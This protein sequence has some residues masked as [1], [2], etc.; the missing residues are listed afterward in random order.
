MRIAILIC[1][2]FALVFLSLIGLSYTS[3]T[4]F[5]VS[6]TD[7]DNGVII[8]NV[9]NVA[10]LVF[11]SS[12]E[13]VQQLEVAVGKNVTVTDISQPVDVSAT[14]DL[15]TR[16]ADWER[17]KRIHEKWGKIKYDLPS[18]LTDPWPGR[19]GLFQLS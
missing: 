2:I 4:S 8:Q 10:C 9:G 6:V 14:S 5:G 1:C 13:G 11:V 7:V 16:W 17:M 12:S 15:T 18:N 19:T 3:G